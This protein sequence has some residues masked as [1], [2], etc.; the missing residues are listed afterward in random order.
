MHEN[1]KI[2]SRCDGR[3]NEKDI[4]L[5]KKPEALLPVVFENLLFDDLNG[6]YISVYLIITQVSHPYIS[7]DTQTHRLDNVF[8]KSKIWIKHFRTSNGAIMS[9]KAL[10]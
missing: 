5:Q 8:L 4:S 9:N 3:A 1:H 6:W 10:Y 7:R 2:G